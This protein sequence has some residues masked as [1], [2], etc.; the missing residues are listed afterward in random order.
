M[1][2]V[3]FVLVACLAATGLISILGNLAILRAPPRAPKE[4]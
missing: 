3:L 1:D 4:T 2:I